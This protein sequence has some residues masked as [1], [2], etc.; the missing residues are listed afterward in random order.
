MSK[1]RAGKRERSRMRARSGLRDRHSSGQ[2]LRGSL[3][4]E[5]DGVDRLQHR[6][7]LRKDFPSGP[8]IAPRSRVMRESKELEPHKELVSNAP[9]ILAQMENISAADA[10]RSILLD[11]VEGL[12]N[13]AELT[14]IYLRYERGLPLSTRYS[15]ILCNALPLH[16]GVL[17]PTKLFFGF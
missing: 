2:A 4:N 15:A 6:I 17:Q 3:G 9:A 1:P 8:S 7:S 13:D 5:S 10:F 16:S 12:P 14:E 11:P